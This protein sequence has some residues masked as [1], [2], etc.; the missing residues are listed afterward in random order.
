M[1]WQTY[2]PLLIELEGSTF[3]NDPSDPGGATKYGIDQRSHPAENIRALTRERAEQIYLAEFST[4]Q[5]RKLPS[6]I[7]F[8]YFDMRVNAGEQTAAHC[9]QRALGV[10]V[11]GAIGP[12]TL[13]ALTAV[14]SRDLIRAFTLQRENYYRTLAYRRPSMKKY[15]GGWLNRCRQTA[16]WALAQLQ[17]PAPTA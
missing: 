12:K 16:Q 15:L 11:D 14:P 7:A 4:S 6:P 8:L 10:T 17:Q 3:E 13:A 5:A 2:F 9:L 1:S